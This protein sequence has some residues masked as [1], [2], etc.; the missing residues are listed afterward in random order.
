[1]AEKW[2]PGAHADVGGGY[3][4][5]SKLPEISMHWMIEQ[6]AKSGYKSIAIPEIPADAALS[7]AHW[8]IGD[9]PANKGS[10]CKDRVSLV[11]GRLPA[12][13]DLDESISV[14]MSSN[15]IPP[16][17]VRGREIKTWK[18]PVECPGPGR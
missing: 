18:Y 17:E 2:F 1:M 4:A 3:G 5:G 15:V 14:R 13:I 11:D 8:S 9:R 7:L 12:G 6:L 10:D 16:L